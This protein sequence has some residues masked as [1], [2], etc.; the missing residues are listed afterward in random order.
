MCFRKPDGTEYTCMCNPAFPLKDFID[1]KP[2]E[3]LVWSVRWW[4]ERIDY[5][6]LLI[7]ATCSSLALEQY[8]NYVVEQEKRAA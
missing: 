2:D 3:K 1:G 8:Q 6:A 4:G 5:D 7:E